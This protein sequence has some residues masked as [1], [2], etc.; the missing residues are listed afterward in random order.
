MTEIVSPFHLGAACVWENPELL[1]LNKLPP[2][3]T[4]TSFP[5][6]SGARARDR[7]R[8][9]W[10]RSLDGPWQFRLAPDPRTAGRWARGELGDAPAESSIEVPG[11]WEMQGWN[12][13]HYTNVQMPFPHDSPHVPAEN[14]TGIYRRTFTVPSSWS[15]LRIVIHFGSADSLLCVY[16]N[17]RFIGLSKDS[18][19]P[20]EFDLSEVV[21]AGAENE[22]MA[23]VVKWS[24]AT[25]V[26]DQDMWWLA[27]LAR[28]VFVYATPKTYLA[29]VAFRPLLDP[30]CRRAEMDLTVTVGFPGALIDGKASVEVQLSDP[31]E[32]P[33][34]ASPLRAKI[35]TRK[36]INDH[37]RL[38]SHFRAP[39]P[40]SRLRLWSAEDPA[41]Y[42]VLVTL[43]SPDG[44]SHAAIRVGFRRI[45]V[46][47]RALLV[48]NRRVLIKGVNRHEHDERRG[49]AMSRELMRRDLVTMKQFNVN[50]VR[51]SHY[52][53]D[54]YWFDLCDE[55]GLYAVDEMNLEGHAFANQLGKNPRYATAWLDRAM[56]MAVRDQNH[57]SVILWSLG[58]E[59]G[60]G[61]NHDAAA[62]WLR[63]FDATRPLHYEGAI[64]RT[65]SQ[66][67]W[68]HGARASDI[69]CP[70]Y[71]SL[72][73]LKA[74][75]AF[76]AR[77][78][79]N[80]PTTLDGRLVSAAAALSPSVLSS[81]RPLPAIALGVHPLDRPVILCE[82]SHAMGN[83]NGALADYFAL[84]KSTPG[85]QGGFVWEW[86]DHGIRRQ[87]SD[88]REYWAYGGDFGD[89][90]NDANFVCDGL[91][92]PDRTPHPALWEFKRL[93]QPVAIELI[94]VARKRVR[95]RNE[96]DFTSL[97]GLSGAWELL[98]EGRAVR[99]GRWPRLALKPGEARE[100]VIP[101]GA[102][103]VAGEC[104]LN[105]RFSTATATPWA[106]RGHEIAW[107]QFALRVQP[108]ARRPRRIVAKEPV[109]IND[110]AKT[111]T[112]RAGD[113]EAVFSRE[114][115]KLTSLEYRGAPILARGPLLQLWRGA[116]DNDGIR[117]H[118]PSEEKALGRWLRLGL[119]TLRHQPLALAWRRNVDGSVTVELKH[120]ATGRKAWNDA[121]HV[122]R[123]TLCASGELWV[124]NEVTFGA[125][126]MTDLPRVGVVL[127]AAPMLEH[128][129]YFGRGPRENYADR[130][131]SEGLGVW[132]GTVTGEYVPY[133][134]PQ[135]HGH[136]TD[137]RWVELSGRGAP[138]LRVGGDP[139]FEFNASHFTAE[140]LFAAKH[141][142]DLSPRPETVLYLDVAQRGLGTASCGPDTREPYRLR[143]RHY[144]FRYVITVR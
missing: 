56:R 2:H 113:V 5:T 46:C 55:L 59:T 48:N 75:C 42:T 76:A 129:C 39:I 91:V 89:Q 41:L 127:H 111:V 136:H 54:S 65:Q 43:R 88:G 57:P 99:R 95:I 130:K 107:A 49:K 16:C 78:A 21:C 25:F 47:N 11:N 103:P 32:R 17:G 58:N 101:A 85:L 22:I 36:D 120:A 12:H 132:N 10:W 83:S 69:I 117:L 4:F 60:Y 92:W 64:S 29:D 24:D 13:P 102:L 26:E 73:E 80:A 38:Q 138:T 68:A 116:T 45:E 135:E 81:A 51:C 15:G 1:S 19:L 79:P 104:H 142:L 87:A 90:P 70:M 35:A 53:P 110:T 28:E 125:E 40:A 33:V 93:A 6:R 122:H 94:D 67:T 143:R 84:F 124:Q 34:L 23:V 74:W 126:D 14:P 77:K 50:A 141:T 131:V 27:G 144:S 37:Y 128:L 71:A 20:A 52:P 137:V 119:P 114:A 100:W 72:E 30:E 3:A 98:V 62:G 86:V 121:L 7:A 134:M 61:P 105:V 18:R 133:V 63:G 97:R 44:D 96:Q 109:A 9:P 31:D 123:Y 139:T 8:S 106:P 140:D 108:R 66:L 115:V 118:E 112:L 82:Y